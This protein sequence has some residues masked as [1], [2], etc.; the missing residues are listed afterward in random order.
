MNKKLI[1]IIVLLAFIGAALSTLLLFQHYSQAEASALVNMLCGGDSAAGCEKVNHS[2]Y[3]SVSGLPLAAFG[4]M[5]YLVIAFVASFSL[6][7]DDLTMKGAGKVILVL[8]GIAL[9]ADLALLG[10]QAFSIGAFCIICISTYLVTTAIF[11][12]LFLKRNQFMAVPWKDPYESKIGKTVLTSWITGSLLLTLTVLALNYALSFKDPAILDER[13]TES[14]YAEYLSSPPQNVDLTGIP[15]YGNVDA[16][17][18]IV[19]FSD[20]L[21]PYCRQMAQYFRQNLPRWRQQV[22]L[23]YM[24]YPL[25]NVCNAHQKETIHQGSC[26]VALGGV[27]ANQQGRFWLYHDYI[28]NKEMINPG[29]LDILRFGKEL[30]MDTTA[31][32]QCLFST[33]LREQLRMQIETGSALGVTSTPRIIVNGKMLPKIGYLNPILKKEA[34]RLGIGPLPGLSEQ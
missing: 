32:S 4:I 17:I 7:G 2:S 13:L 6:T 20:F 10:L 21:C 1:L 30:G 8:T 16:P 11:V 5:F 27:C 24:S 14:A 12:L 26:W 19:I 33:P 31:F 34:E 25:D 29:H 28:Y 23:Y 3:S 18:R 9:L 15:H 22:V